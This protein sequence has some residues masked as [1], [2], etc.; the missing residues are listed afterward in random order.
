MSIKAIRH[1]AQDRMEVLL[2]GDIGIVLNGILFRSFREDQALL[3]PHNTPTALIYKIRTVID[4]G[5]SKPKKEVTLC[6]ICSSGPTF[7]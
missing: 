4:K 3:L 6:S 1:V 2:R 5:Q 7:Q